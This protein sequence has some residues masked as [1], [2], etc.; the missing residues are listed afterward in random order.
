MAQGNADWIVGRGNPNPPH[1]HQGGIA[2][3]PAQTQRFTRQTSGG[4][5]S[6]PKDV[7]T[8][9]QTLWQTA[10]WLKVE[11]VVAHLVVPFFRL[12]RRERPRLARP[13]TQAN[14]RVA[15]QAGPARRKACR[16]QTRP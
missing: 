16:P 12:Q 6:L 7:F 2:S 1:G 3:D 15:D 11:I 14:I 8:L 9:W 10:N 13:E 5:A 4:R